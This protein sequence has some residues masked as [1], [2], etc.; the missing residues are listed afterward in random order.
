[1]SQNL[2]SLTE[3]QGAEEQQYLVFTLRGE[4]F[5]LGLL[6][7]REIIEYNQLTEVPLMPDTVRGVI[8]LR[9]AVVPVIDLSSSFW[10]QRATPGK[11]TCIVI[12]ELDD[13]AKQRVMGILVDSVNKVVEIPRADIEPPPSFGTKIRTDF[14]AGMGKLDDHFVIILNAARVLSV[15]QLAALQEDLQQVPAEAV[16]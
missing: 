2:L 5:A 6:N 16:A 15:E 11:R 7:V 14:I 8:N 4:L 12:V 10:K 13:S 3:A 1:M 9:G